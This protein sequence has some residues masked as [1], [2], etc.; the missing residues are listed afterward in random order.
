MSKVIFNSAL[1][2]ILILFFFLLNLIPLWDLRIL[3]IA[4]RSLNGFWGVFFAPFLHADFSHLMSNLMPLWVLLLVLAIFYKDYYW[5]VFWVTLGA[6]G[7]LT[8]LIGSS[9]GIHL[10][11][12]GLVFALA[13]FI[14]VSGFLR[15][16]LI[17]IVVGCL[18]AFFYNYLLGGLLPSFSSTRANISYSSHWS[19]IIAGVGVAFLF[20]Y[21]GRKQTSYLEQNETSNNHY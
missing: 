8:W 6:S 1:P 15:R 5:K 19:G 13:V 12:S 2:I 18:V 4:P 21:L 16:E 7:F 10:G 11:A 20:A 17:L 9:S 3:G 14:A